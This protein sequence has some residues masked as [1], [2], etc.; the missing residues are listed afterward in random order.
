M[1]PDDDPR[2]PA[3]S[4]QAVVNARELLLSAQPGALFLLDHAGVVQQVGGDWTS[5]TETEP[6]EIIGRPLASLVRLPAATYPEG[7]LGGD[8]RS[9]E[10]ALLTRTGQLRVSVSWRRHGEVI[11]G[12]IERLAKSQGPQA[13]SERQA[14]MRSL[15]QA[16]YCLGTALDAGQGNHVQ[17]MVS[18]ATRLAQALALG[19]EELQA[20]RWGAALHDVGKSRVPPEILWKPGPLSAEE[21]DIVIQHP[22]WGTEIIQPLEF[23]PPGVTAAVRHH[24]ERFDGQGYPAGLSGEAIPMTARIVAIA[25]VFDA[26]TSARPYKAAWTHQRAAEFLIGGA[27]TQ[28]DAWLVRVFVLDVLG[29][30]L[31]E[32]GGAQD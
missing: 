15:D 27:G 24:H 11:A 4:A 26:L 8:G 28:F 9:N 18:Y 20:V 25:D 21:F 6:D 19:P 23:L 10:A 32:E 3:L 1:L 17:R 22:V 16:V 12:Q 31:P 5:V 13:S 29:L 30:P 7:L 14:F 2:F